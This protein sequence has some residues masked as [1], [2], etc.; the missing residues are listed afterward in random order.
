[1][2]EWLAL[3]IYVREKWKVD[4]VAALRQHLVTSVYGEITGYLIFRKVYSSLT[5]RL[6][7]Y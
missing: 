5:K 2:I 1:M 6:V 3:V 4:S 7:H